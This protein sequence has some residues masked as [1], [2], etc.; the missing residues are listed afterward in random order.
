MNQ[1][2]T[3]QTREIR[4]SAKEQVFVTVYIEGQLFGI[5]VE[6][7]QD[8]LIPSN[9]AKIPLASKEIA[10]SINLRGRIV[11]VVDLRL[12][13]GLPPSESSKNMCT[14]VEHDND[15][16]SLKVDD[17]G[18]VIT[19]PVDKIEANPGTLGQ[20]WRAVSKG[21]VRLENELM[22]VIDIDYLFREAKTKAA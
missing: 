12:W 7:V 6:R 15:L 8:I 17:V 19:L 10:G 11:T 22:I 1:V 20:P 3:A 2:A 13:L 9:I 16:Y 14:T 4:A 21:V 5:P 18:A